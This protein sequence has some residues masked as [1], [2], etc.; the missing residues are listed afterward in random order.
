[1]FRTRTMLQTAQVKIRQLDD[2]LKD[3]D[4]K[5]QRMERK[6]QILQETTD[7]INRNFKALQDSEMLTSRL[8]GALATLKTDIDIVRNSV[9]ALSAENEKTLEAAEKLATL[10]E[11]IKLLEDRIDEMNKARESVARLA[12]ELQNLNREAKDHL[13]MAQDLRKQPS[14][15]SARPV[16]DEGAPPQSVRANV[17]RLKR[18]GWTIEEIARSLG[19]SKGEVELILELGSKN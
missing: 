1:M 11:S 13:K 4:E 2:A 5:Y 18:A 3:A 6:N 10:D 17:I 16:S 14:E 12:T 15:R 8:D 7:G 19:I 9:A